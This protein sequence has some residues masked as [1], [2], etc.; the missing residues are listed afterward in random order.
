MKVLRLWHAAV[1]SEYRKKVRAIAA[2]PDVDL[3]L[4][5][6]PAWHEGG[7]RVRYTPDAGIDT[8]YG[9]RT[10]RIAHP[11][12][13]RRYWF[14]NGLVSV[15]RTFRPDIVDMEEEPFSAVVCQVMTWCRTL[16]IPAKFIFH[17]AH[18]IFEPIS[19]KFGRYERKALAC[20]HGAVARN[21]QAASRLRSIG[22]QGPIARIGN[23][24]D[25]SCFIPQSGVEN[26]PLPDLQGP[27][28]SCRRRSARRA[29]WT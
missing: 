7:Q 17:T 10:G 5:I 21:D 23:G 27:R 25:L 28:S 26:D 14:V 11:D 13:I 4:L 8:G 12:N 9:I 24:I 3:M 16:R 18:N 6:P 22:F 29:S 1:V 20:G 2:I 15:L 19:G